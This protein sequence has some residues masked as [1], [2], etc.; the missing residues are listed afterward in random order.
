MKTKVDNILLNQ[1]FIMQVLVRTTPDEVHIR[2]TIPRSSSN[3]EYRK[4]T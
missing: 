3:F 2:T 1:Y 4:R